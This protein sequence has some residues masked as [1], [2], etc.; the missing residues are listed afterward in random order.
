MAKTAYDTVTKRLQ[1]FKPQPRAVASPAVGR[2]LSKPAES[3]PKSMREAIE[4]AL[5]G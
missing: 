1:A 5:T 3:Q 2:R 4:N